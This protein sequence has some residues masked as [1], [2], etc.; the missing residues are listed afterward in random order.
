MPEIIESHLIAGSTVNFMTFFDYHH[1]YKKC[2]NGAA[3]L[4]LID[5]SKN[6]GFLPATST[7]SG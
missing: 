3:S 4:P 7:K 5:E 2:E 1:H 6:D